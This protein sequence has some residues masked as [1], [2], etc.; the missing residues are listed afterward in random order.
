MCPSVV[1][2]LAAYGNGNGADP[3]LG[4]DGL[5]SFHE[6][7]Q[8]AGV[9]IDAVGHGRDALPERGV[10]SDDRVTTKRAPASASGSATRTGS[11]P[12][13]STPA[14]GQCEVVEELPVLDR[15]WRLREHGVGPLREGLV[16]QVLVPACVVRPFQRQGRRDH[17]AGNCGGRGRIRID[18]DQQ[19]VYRGSITSRRTPR[20]LASRRRRE[21]SWI[22]N[23]VRAPPCVDTNGFVPTSIQTSLSPNRCGPASQTP[24]RPS[25]THLAD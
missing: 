10:G 1:P 2:A 8:S 6:A 15:P 24:I 9:R 17:V 21:P 25:A 18:R 5:T 23:P 4:V 12:S 11:R 7:E 16:V 3:R 20:R 22:G 13:T 14:H 19:V